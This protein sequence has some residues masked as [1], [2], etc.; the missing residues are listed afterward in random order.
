MDAPI[1]G[2][3]NQMTICDTMKFGKWMRMAYKTHAI[4]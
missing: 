1:L 2:V 3:K 4:I